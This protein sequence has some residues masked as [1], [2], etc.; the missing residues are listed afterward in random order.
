MSIQYWLDLGVDY[1][2]VASSDV[3]HR[4]QRP[5]YPWE[6]L[7][8]RLVEYGTD[9]GVEFLIYGKSI[10]KLVPSGRVLE[11]LNALEAEGASLLTTERYCTNSWETASGFL[12]GTRLE[13]PQCSEVVIDPEG[14]I[15]SCCWYEISPG[16]FDLT[17]IEF[18]TGMERLRSA[19][20]CRALDRGD[21][22]H[23]AEIAQVDSDLARR[24]RNQVG[25]C[26]A[27]RLFVLRLVCQPEYD[28]LRVAPLAARESAF[29][30]TRLGAKALHQLLNR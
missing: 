2:Q 21:I 3:F 10:A 12:S 5:A 4:R 30:A 14:W 25:D 18:A 26:G 15:H 13:Y 16:L 27:C 20:F 9:Y 19:P 24:V 8:C 29:F 22:L 17:E 11:N 7:E 28:W 1:F 23:I 6:T